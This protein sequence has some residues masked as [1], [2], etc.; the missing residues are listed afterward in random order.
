MAK[1]VNAVLSI[2]FPRLSHQHIWEPMNSNGDAYA[3][4]CGAWKGEQLWI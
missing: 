1:L 2:L 4:K 3:C